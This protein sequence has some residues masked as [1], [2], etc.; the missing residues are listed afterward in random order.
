MLQ[1]SRKDDLSDLSTCTS[2][3]LGREDAITSGVA[4]GIFIAV[5]GSEDNGLGEVEFAQEWHLVTHHHDIVAIDGT[6]Y[7]EFDEVTYCSHT[8]GHVEGRFVG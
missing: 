4:V 8:Q 1:G 6:L 2:K 3:H 5:F 7:T